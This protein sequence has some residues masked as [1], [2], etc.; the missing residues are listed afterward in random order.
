MTNYRQLALDGTKD[1]RNLLKQRFES[2]IYKGERVSVGESASE[3]EIERLKRRIT[4]IWPHIDMTKKL[5]KQQV[6]LDSDIL[7][8]NQC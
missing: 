3:E 8:K 5:T 2:L 6:S 7:I 1:A 4:D